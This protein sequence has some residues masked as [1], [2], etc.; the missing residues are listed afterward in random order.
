MSS[1]EYVVIEFKEPLSSRIARSL[2]R[3]FLVLLNP[4]QTFSEIA[5][6]PDVIGPSVIFCLILAINTLSRY[7]EATFVT[8]VL[9][10]NGQESIIKLAELVL[11]PQAL[12]LNLINIA[13]RLG[14]GWLLGYLLIRFLGGFFG[15]DPGSKEAFSGIGYTMSVSMLELLAMLTLSI[16]AYQGIGSITISVPSNATLSTIISE[17]TS[18]TQALMVERGLASIIS[19]SRFVWF[20]SRAW[21]CA[22]FIASYE[23]MCRTGLAKAT[24]LGMLTYLVIY[25]VRGF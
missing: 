7:F 15:R 13:S 18:E 17:V 1:E 19:I 23:A 22:L 14:F 10:S 6:K 12:S 3:I 4:F 2:S 25:L 21:T 5:E 11:T 20:L 24:I 16:V 9:K 8:V